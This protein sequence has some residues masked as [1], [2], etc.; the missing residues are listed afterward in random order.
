MRTFTRPGLLSETLLHR[1]GMAL[2][3]LCLVHCMVLPLMLA[4][5][6]VVMMAAV[7]DGWIENEWFHAALIVP[8]VLVSGPA[9]WR[10]GGVRTGVLVAAL[11]ALT[12]ALFVANERLETGLTVAGAVGLL[13]AHWA[14]LRQRKAHGL[15]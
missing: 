1:A 6:P 10:S 3:G 13:V 14:T 4:A 7:P 15:A 9:L 2:S 5:A 12:G 11:A 8:V